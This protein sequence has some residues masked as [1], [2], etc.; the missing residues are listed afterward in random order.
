MRRADAVNAFLVRYGAQD[1][2]ITTA[3]DGKRVPEVDNKTKEG[4][5]MNRRV[6]LTVTD[7]TGRVIKEGGISDVLPS[8]LDKLNAMQKRQQEC[9][10]QILKKLDKLDDILAGLRNLQGE[11]DKLRAELND[12]RNQLNAL[13]DQ[14][15][16]LPKPL[17]SQQT[18]DIAH[19]EAMGALDEAQRR[20]RKFSNVAINI[21]P[22]IGSNRTGDFSIS[23]RGSFFSPFGGDGVRAVQAQGE[24]MYYPGRQE[25]QFDIGLVNRFATNFQAGAFGSFKYL[26][27]KQYQS[28]GGLGQAAF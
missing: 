17:T 26:N 4:R 12:Q 24:Y 1:S 14:V 25:G 19:T 2:Q 6:V 18:T 28:G 15:N 13:K 5:F 7:G 22:N 23:G 10:D 21:G 11:N 16:G 27:L 3:G 20:N 8:L 9:C